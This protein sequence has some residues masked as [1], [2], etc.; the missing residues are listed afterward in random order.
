[1]FA[2]SE[3]FSIPIDSIP[4][5]YSI[6]HDFLGTAGL[7]KTTLAGSIAEKTKAA[8]ANRD[9]RQSGYCVTEKQN[10]RKTMDLTFETKCWQNDYKLMLMTDH[11]QR[12]IANCNVKFADRQLIINNV[13][14]QDIVLAASEALKRTG[15]IDHVYIAEE[16]SE[17]ALD[18]FGL[19]R[20]SFKG[21]Y[22]YS[23]SELTGIFLC[24]TKYL[25]HFSSDSYIPSKYKKSHWIEDAIKI[26]EKNPDIVVANPTWNFK[27]GEAEKES[28]SK[29]DD[30][31]FFVGQGFSD[32]CYLINT[33][34]FK[35]KIYNYK[36]PASERYPKYGGELFEKRVDSFM[37]V[38][39]KK[40]ITSTEVSYRSRN[41]RKYQ[42]YLEKS[43]IVRI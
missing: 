17:K 14:D 38:Q 25:L 2:L 21:G 30:G 3:I 10:R 34:I 15:T 4:G 33:Q 9:G 42:Y 26:M 19:E 35:D 23:I 32:Q 40:R 20:D 13:N 39:G 27:W 5:L 16:Y 24:K 31:K 41:I 28:A 29:T 7:G 12:M 11:L 37:R 22:Y 8:F 1:M 36:H 43:G 18:Y 6:F